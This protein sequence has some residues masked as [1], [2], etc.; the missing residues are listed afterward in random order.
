MG[1]VPVCIIMSFLVIK[2]ELC[3]VGKYIRDGTTS[4]DRA[5]GLTRFLLTNSLKCILNF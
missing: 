4:G 2:M 3:L 5:K 1:I